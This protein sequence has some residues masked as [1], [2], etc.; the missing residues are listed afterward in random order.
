MMLIMSAT[1]TN[2]KYLLRFNFTLLFMLYDAS[3]RYATGHDITEHSVL[4]HEYYTKES[5]NK[6][7]VHLTIDTGFLN[8]ELGFKGYVR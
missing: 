2:T 7:P 5:K 3:F 8:G 4:I 1:A 6:N